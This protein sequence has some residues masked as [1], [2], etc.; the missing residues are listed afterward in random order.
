MEMMLVLAIL[1]AVMLI[2]W[3]MLRKPLNKSVVQDAAQ[4]LQRD[5]R[6]CRL[7]AI[8]T[9]KPWVIQYRTATA[10]YYI[11]TQIQTETIEQASAAEDEPADHDPG[12]RPNSLQRRPPASDEA[13]EDA[14]L[15]DQGV[16]QLPEGTLFS[17]DTTAFPRDTT[18]EIETWQDDDAKSGRTTPTP[19][20]SEDREMVEP[21]PWSAPIRFYPSGRCDP[22]KI[23]LSSDQGYRTEVNVQGLAGRITISPVHR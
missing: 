14:A 15:V 19:S 12:R 17:R 4:Q 1:S 13:V 20:E 16:R 18:A 6:T 22:A 5:L 9:G 10:E 11:G 7:K 3:P 2:S 8:E 21:A 23:A